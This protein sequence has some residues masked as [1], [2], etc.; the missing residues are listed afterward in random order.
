[1]SKIRGYRQLSPDEIQLINKI[2]IHGECLNLLIEE[3]DQHL[4]CAIDYENPEQYQT[5]DEADRWLAK[6][7]TDLQTGLMALTRAVAKPEG[8]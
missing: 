6:G 5:I 8:F 4:S 7:R 3:I 1:M 2:K